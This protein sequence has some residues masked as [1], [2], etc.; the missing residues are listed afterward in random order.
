MKNSKT[1][2]GNIL[3]IGIGNSGRRDD[4]LGW[5]FTDMA[6]HL[7]YKEMDCEFRYQLQVE[8]VLMVCRYDKVVFADASHTSIKEGFEIKSIKPA[9]HYFFSSHMQSPETILYLAKELYNKTPEA[10]TL[11]ISGHNWGLGTVLSRA[12]QENLQNAFR[13]FKSR[14]VQSNKESAE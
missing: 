13:F 5:K 11:A 2:K 3:L 6:R 8:D 14:F 9:G 12:A 10:Y 1:E 7:G 4:G